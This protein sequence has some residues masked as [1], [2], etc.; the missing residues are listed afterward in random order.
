MCS[1]TEFN[2]VWI[3][4]RARHSILR[5]HSAFI[6]GMPT[7]ARSLCPWAKPLYY[8]LNGKIIYVLSKKKPIR[9]ECNSIYERKSTNN[10]TTSPT[11]LFTSQSIHFPLL[12]I[13]A[14]NLATT[15]PLGKKKNL[16]RC[17]E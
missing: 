1:I 9:F 5:S 2:S 10:I 3:D 12:S 17:L 14:S 13:L 8:Y 4:R 11:F 16:L 15:Y 6:D 7:Y